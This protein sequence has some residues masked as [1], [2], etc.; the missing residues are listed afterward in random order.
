MVC[1]I[2]FYSRYPRNIL[3]INVHFPMV[4][5]GLLRTLLMHFAL[6]ED[7]DFRKYSTYLQEQRVWCDEAFHSRNR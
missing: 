3:I 2:R 5:K 1:L 7:V 6:V 4:T